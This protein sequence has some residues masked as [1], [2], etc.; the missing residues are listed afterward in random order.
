MKKINPAFFYLGGFI[1]TLIIFVVIHN[2]NK[3]SIATDNNVMISSDNINGKQMPEDAIHK[4]LKNP[5]AQSPTKN[6]V[7]P[8][9][10]QHMNELKMAVEKYPKDTL[11]IREYADFLSE[12]HMDAQAISNYQKI[13]K[14]NPRRV[15][16]LNSL[17]YLYFDN[18]DLNSAKI[19]LNKILVIDKNNVDALYNLG[20]ISA[21]MGD[22]V[23]ARLLWTRIIKEFPKSP[24]VQKAKESIAQL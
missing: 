6:N 5:I 14:I 9:I 19:T 16:I 17:V 15:D 3:S 23:Q 11:K 18:K 22:R 1:I 24:L 10:K 8:S 20:A 12:A 13:L 21:N 2:N 4:G 7:L